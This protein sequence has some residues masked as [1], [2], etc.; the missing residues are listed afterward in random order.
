MF[1][2]ESF[3]TQNLPGKTVFNF[4]ISFLH[5]N[6]IKKRFLKLKKHFIKEVLRIF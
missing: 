1:F 5:K 2:K 6:I 3:K 4:E